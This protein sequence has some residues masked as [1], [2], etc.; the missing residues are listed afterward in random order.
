MEEFFKRFLSTIIILPI[1]L[2]F[3]LLGSYYFILLISFCFV[4]SVYEWQKMKISL[5]TKI[6]G[7]L[8]LIFSFYSIFKLRNDFNDDYFIFLFIT[9]ICISSDLGGYFFGKIFKGPKL[10][11]LSPKKTYSG[12]FGSFALSY[13]SYFICLNY[14]LFDEN[15]KLNIILFVFLVSSTSQLGD[16]IVSYFKRLSKIKDTGNIIPGHGGILD[17]ID[18]MIFAFPISYLILFTDYFKIIA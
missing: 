9:L 8:F 7:S 18:G 13:L 6:I 14:S 4:I 3:V 17:R 11:K 15:Y 10:T 2:Y 5:N 12:M 1:S 16:I